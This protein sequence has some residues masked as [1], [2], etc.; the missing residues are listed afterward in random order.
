MVPEGGSKTFDV[1][2]M[3]LFNEDGSRLGLM[4]I[5]RDVTLRKNTEHDLNKR[6]AIL[7]AL[8]ACDG[9]LHSAE[10]WKK[11]VLDV[12]GLLGSS[13]GFSRVSLF[14]NMADAMHSALRAQSLLLE[15]LRRTHISRSST[16]RCI[17]LT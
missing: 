6:S 12:L 3:P 16:S 14:K 13:S 4:V 1:I 8:I 5:A 10:S 17:M 9:I 11:V 7:D 2:K 15:C